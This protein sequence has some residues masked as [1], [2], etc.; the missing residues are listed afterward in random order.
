MIID[1]IV[2]KRASYLST[3]LFFPSSWGQ[4]IL[5]QLPS[6]CFSALKCL[7]T[8][9]GRIKCIFFSLVSEPPGYGPLWGHLL[10]F[11][12]RRQLLLW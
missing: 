2:D 9:H 5:E 8:L 1:K 7:M 12:P 3:F 11:H 6:F 10:F 4:I